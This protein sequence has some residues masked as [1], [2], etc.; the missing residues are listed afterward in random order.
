[1]HNE[2]PATKLFDS[3]IEIDFHRFSNV[4]AHDAISLFGQRHTVFCCATTA[5]P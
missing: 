4:D 1:M 5:T 2:W 3:R